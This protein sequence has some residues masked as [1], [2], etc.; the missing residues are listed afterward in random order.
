MIF[1]KCYTFVFFE[2]TKIKNNKY[3]SSKQENTDFTMATF[4]NPQKLEK[5]EFVANLC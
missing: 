1:L 4:G 3:N 5:F 2:E